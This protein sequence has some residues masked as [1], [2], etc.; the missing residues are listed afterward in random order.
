M[1]VNTFQLNNVLPND[2]QIATKIL[3]V[4]SYTVLY[5]RGK[6]NIFIVIIIYFRKRF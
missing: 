1:A 2:V 6:K 5:S 4:R 3:V